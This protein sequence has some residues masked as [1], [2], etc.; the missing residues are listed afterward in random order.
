M[1]ILYFGPSSFFRAC[2]VLCF[3][4]LS[5]CLQKSVS[6]DCR[7]LA[8]LSL[9]SFPFPL[10]LPSFQAQFYFLRNFPR[11]TSLTKSDPDSGLLSLR[12]ICSDPKLHTLTLPLL[13]AF[14]GPNGY[15]SMFSFPGCVSP[16]ARQAEYAPGLLDCSALGTEVQTCQSRGVRVLLSVKGDGL[17]SVGG[18]TLFGN[19]AASTKPLGPFFSAKGLV[20]RQE[21]H[22]PTFN[23]PGIHMG[24][25]P[26]VVNASK[27][28]PL[29]AVEP[30][31]IAPSSTPVPLDA[32]FTAVPLDP[33][34][35][36][37]PLDASFTPL[38]LDPSFTPL[39]LDSSSTPLPLDPSATPIP[40][41][42]PITAGPAPPFP[43]L[44]NANHAPS[45]LA[46][47][48]FSLFGEGHTERADLRPLGP[49]APSGASPESL[50][51]T[52]WINPILTEL[53]R[54]LGEE[55]VLDG[56]DVQL[57]A[58]W[59]GT[60]QDAQFKDLV[61]SLEGLHDEAWKESGGVKGGPDDLGADG[62]GVVYFGWVGGA[63]K[64]RS[65][66]LEVRADTKRVGW[67]EWNGGM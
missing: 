35:T 16:N 49:D 26:V 20:V 61:N 5:A 3:Y 31:L 19:P 56:F 38:P 1:G 54:P 58:E 55:V 4:T 37:V 7:P 46:L 48:L 24:H 45:A 41:V 9:F 59:E 63:L 36:A 18:N 17:G 34:F 25:G 65:K 51:G 40:L 50:N 57:P 6:P 67:V 32:S 2:V 62:K 52:D 23:L 15:P 29:I 21:Q 44:F 22:M 53:Q 60:Y 14:Y 28:R 11:P 42:L 27:P 64:V 30:I 66:G 47:T 13:S 10:S 43:N 12:T 8:R 39:P 33:S